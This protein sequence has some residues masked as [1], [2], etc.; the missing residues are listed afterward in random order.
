ME[1]GCKWNQEELCMVGKI[2]VGI[3]IFLV[4]VVML[5]TTGDIIMVFLCG[6]NFKFWF[7]KNGS[8]IK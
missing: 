1:L 2:V 5:V 7:G 4:R 8:R 6:D 3:H